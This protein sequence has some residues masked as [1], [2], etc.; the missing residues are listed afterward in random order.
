MEEFKTKNNENLNLTLGLMSTEIKI[1]NRNINNYIQS[2]DKGSLIMAN[3]TKALV[4]VGVAQ[5]I[6]T[7]L[8]IL[9]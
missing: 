8:Q 7:A 9:I 6:A 2:V 1:L 5:V 3:L 4:F